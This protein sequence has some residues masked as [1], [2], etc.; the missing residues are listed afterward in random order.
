MRTLPRFAACCAAAAVLAA[1]AGCS[2][3]PAG[4]TTANSNGAPVVIDSGPASVYDGIQLSKPFARPAF[5]L[6]DGAGQSYAF[7]QQTA[8][9]MTLLYFGY[10]HC[11]DVCPTTMADLAA[12]LRALPAAQRARIT[13]VF[14]TTD[15][16]RDTPAVLTTWLG[17]FNPAFIGLTGSFSV[18]QQAAAS[19]GITIDPP[20]QQADGNYTITHGAEVL[21]FTP[22][23][24]A[25]VLWT[26]GTT[27]AQYDHDLPLLL[28]GKDLAGGPGGAGGGS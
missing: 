17:Q 12:A 23:N 3:S 7:A 26:A 22:D 2:A 9:R 28:A 18:I 24:E 11:P 13:V 19:V 5:T 10:T 20:V 8:G 4:G 6:T 1:A 14:V 21:A 15:P 25:H 27:P 16:A